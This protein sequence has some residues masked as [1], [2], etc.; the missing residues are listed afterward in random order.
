MSEEQIGTPGSNADNSVNGNRFLAAKDK[1][2][3][4]CQQSFTSSS[5]GRHLDLYIKEKNPKP[6][7]GIHEVERIKKLRGGI[8]RRTPRNSTSNTKREGS[9]PGGT[10]GAQDGRSPQNERSMLGNGSPPVRG[11]GPGG[12]PDMMG[13]GKPIYYLNSHPW[14]ATGVINNIPSSRK[15]AARAQEAAER[16]RAPKLEGRERSVSRQMLAKTT[17]EQ[18]Q[19]ITEAM[20]NAKAAELALREIMGSIRS[21]K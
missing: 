21:A 3:P 6:P 1:L 14:E 16:D 9:T 20:D 10:P 17:F 13:G 12:I 15:E 4:F 7:D 2:C 11:D 8:T 18:K 19:K 5:L